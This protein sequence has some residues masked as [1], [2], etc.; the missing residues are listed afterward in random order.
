LVGTAAPT[1]LLYQPRM[2]GD[3]DYGEIGGMKIGRG[4]EDSE[5]TCPSATLSTRNHTWPDPCLNPG[6]SGGKPATNRLSYGAALIA[7]YLDY[8]PDLLRI[9]FK[10]ATDRH[11]S[12]SWAKWI[13]ITRSLSTSLKF[14]SVLS[15]NLLT[16]LPN[17]SCFQVF[18]LNVYLGFGILIAMTTNSSIFR[19]IILYNIRA[20]CCISW[21]LF[22]TVV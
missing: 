8:I 12:Q 20:C 14:T 10:S 9:I 16:S 3:G 19:N 17:D 7:T 1:G 22:N 6:R 18:E 2:I 5:K 11:G 13:Y 21:A 15:S 4:T